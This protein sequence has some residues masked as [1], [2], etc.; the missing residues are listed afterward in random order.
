MNSWN[1]WPPV[2]G[3]PRYHHAATILGTRS[4]A[5]IDPSLFLRWCF[6]DPQG[7]PIE[8]AA[9]HDRLQAFL[10]QHPRALVELPRD[11]GKSF[12]V[13]GRILWELG[14]NPALRVKVV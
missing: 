2:C 3:T 1:N 5:R 6:T 8:Q 14:R 11:H 7:R 9:V 10:S 4:L 13:C 12:Q